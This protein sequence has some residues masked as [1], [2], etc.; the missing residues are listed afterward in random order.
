LCFSFET[1]EKHFEEALARVREINEV[2]I[3][4]KWEPLFN[5]LGQTC[6]KLKKYEKALEYH[7]QVFWK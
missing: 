5:N 7:Q 3:A 2:I 6:R 4:D 1:A